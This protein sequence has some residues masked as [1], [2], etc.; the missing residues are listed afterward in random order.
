MLT[1]TVFAADS[2]SSTRPNDKKPIVAFMPIVDKSNVKYGI[3]MVAVV[4][5]A[6]LKKLPLG[7]SPAKR[8]FRTLTVENRKYI[9]IK[10]YKILFCM[11]QK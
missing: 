6:L 2:A 10:S 9:L 8:A 4:N 7:V 1:G 11:I 5:K 3:E